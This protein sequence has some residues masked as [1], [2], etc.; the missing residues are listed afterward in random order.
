M[1]EQ[2]VNAPLVASAVAVI[3]AGSRTLA[4]TFRVIT[5]RAQNRFELR[6]WRG[7]RQDSHERLDVHTSTVRETEQELRSLL[8][9][10]ITDRELWRAMKSGYA[11]AME[12]ER[13]RTLFYT[14]F[15]SITRRVFH[16]SGI[17]P[18]IEFVAQRAVAGGTTTPDD[19]LVTYADGALTDLLRAM[20]IDCGFEI[21]FRDLTRDVFRAA[22][23]IRERLST[24][25]AGIEMIGAVLFREQAAYRV[26]RLT[27]STTPIPFVVVLRNP[28][29][30]IMID[31]VLIGEAAVSIL[32]SFTRS[33]FHIDQEHGYELIPFLHELM[34]RKRPSE[35]FTALG[36]HKHG[37]TL[38][39]RE[40]LDHLETTS[41][42]FTFAPGTHGLVMLVFA[43]PDM[44]LVFK[45]LRDRFKPPKRTTRREVK[46]TYQLV[47][48]HD[49][50][51]RLIDA[52]E[53][54]HL[55]LFR[56]RFD[57]DLLSELLDECGS[58][59]SFDGELMTLE[60]VYIERRVTPLNL[61]IHHPEL[62]LGPH[63]PAADARAAVID[64]GQAIRDMAVANVFPGDLLLKN[65]GLTRHGRVVFYDYDELVR[66]TE[67][68]FRSLPEPLPGHEMDDTPMWGVGPH[69]IF[70]EE[71]GSFLGLPEELRA[72]FMEHHRDLLTADWWLNIQ[73]R[74][75]AGELIEIPPYS[76]EFRVN[77]VRLD[78]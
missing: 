54:E 49:R 10:A 68:V 29:D 66:V 47:F 55:Q 77:R 48:K 50:A 57:A 59:T 61:V 35:L 76:D 12:K 24:D 75:G 53:F 14:F 30:G 11:R 22:E 13:S 2:N 8:A 9:D 58:T 19:H 67:C 7:Q 4:E 20:M 6:D 43:M 40:I 41:H 73:R 65:F 3:S 18:D 17:D 31:A 34:P 23:F 64:Y 32:F 60:H 51:G 26:G 1:S 69:D 15:N 56:H 45:V 25:V 72:V 46:A 70:P 28:Q 71:F 62:A 42:R 36:Y 33:H 5:A 21:G 37:K 78:T 63:T 38:L 44:D 16:T 39:Y 52:Q 74:V 27:T